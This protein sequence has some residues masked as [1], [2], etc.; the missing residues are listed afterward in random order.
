MKF[1]TLQELEDVEEIV[2]GHIL[3]TERERVHIRSALS[4]TLALDIYSPINVPPF[5]KSLMDGY[6]LRSKDTLKASESSPLEF[7]IIER[8]DAGKIP[9]K[10]ITSKTCSYIATGAP[11]P[12]GADCVVK[13]EDTY[14]RK[15][16]LRI[17]K[18]LFRGENIIPIGA[19]F[20]KGDMVLREGKLLTPADLA[21]LAYLGF[22][23][24]KVKRKPKVAIISTGDEIQDVGESLKYGNSY[25][26][27]SHLLGALVER[28]DAKP[29]YLGIS[30]DE[31]ETLK[32]KISE[33]LEA[34]LVLLSAGASQG[35]RDFLVNAISELG[36]VLIHGIA[37]K[38]GK[39]TIVGVAKGKLIIGLP[40]HPFSCAVTFLILVKPLILK[41]L[42][43]AYEPEFS[44]KIAASKLYSVKGRRQILP[45]RIE[46][47]KVF[48]VFYG[49]GFL[50]SLIKAD[51]FAL[52]EK[53]V[54]F[55]E[56]GEKVKV[57]KSDF[58]EG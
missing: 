27:N 16:K 21:I 34:D 37:L 9:E 24:V 41:M 31:P 10:K 55:V 58:H 19:D 26:V 4:R 49:S 54:E 56:V 51:G 7:R 38:P 43:R 2:K 35:S 15:G 14:E 5:E 3:K 30:Q 40:G 36:E 46:R 42:G 12:M 47:D 22:R 17:S 25:D 45:V 13:I 53:E 23:E 29:L 32:E 1:L 48:S 6:A 8:I 20:K 57:M 28:L 11:L 52:I 33:A 39:P 44:E 50:Q 18:S